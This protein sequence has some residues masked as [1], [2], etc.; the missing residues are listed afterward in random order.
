MTWIVKTYGKDIKE[1]C[2]NQ[3]TDLARFLLRVNW[4]EF[5]EMLE[6]IAASVRFDVKFWL[7]P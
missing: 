1:P 7:Q 5:M 4:L 2:G 3:A 6:G